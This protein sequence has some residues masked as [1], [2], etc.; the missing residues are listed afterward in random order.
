MNLESLNETNFLL[1]VAK[2]YNS[3]L[4]ASDAEFK[5]DINRIK[6]IRKL[7][8]RYQHTN[9]L[10]E[11]LIL[12]HIII[13]SNVFEAEI[14]CKILFFKLDDQIRFVKPFL[15]FLGILPSILYKMGTKDIV[16]TDDIDMDLGIVKIL[17]GI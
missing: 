14:C 5:E 15:I 6:Y 9:V 2:H 11:R 3:R 4:C 7:I 13:L 1:F 12:N 8:T 16:I 10:K 17:R